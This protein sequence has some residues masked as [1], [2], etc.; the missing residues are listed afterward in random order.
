MASIQFIMRIGFEKDSI[1]V[2][3]L[4]LAAVKIMA[5]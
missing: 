5:F 4:I 3:G 1:D 2:I